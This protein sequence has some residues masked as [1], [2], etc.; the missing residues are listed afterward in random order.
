M[1]GCIGHQGIWPVKVGLHELHISCCQ[2]G[3]HLECILIE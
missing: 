2:G 3:P 1:A